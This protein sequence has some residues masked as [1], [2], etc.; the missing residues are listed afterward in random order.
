MSRLSAE[1]RIGRELEPGEIVDHNNGN[2]INDSWDEIAISNNC[3]NIINRHVESRSNTGHCGIFQ[4]DINFFQVYWTQGPHFKREKRYKSFP[5]LEDAIEFRDLMYAEHM[6]PQVING[7]ALNV[8][9]DTYVKGQQTQIVILQSLITYCQQLQHQSQQQQQ[10]QLIW[11]QML[12]EIT[13]EAFQQQ[14]LHNHQLVN[15]YFLSVYDESIPILKQKR[16]ELQ[17]QLNQQLS[18]Q[19]LQGIDPTLLSENETPIH[20]LVQGFGEHS[21]V[22]DCAEFHMPLPIE[23]RW[24]VASDVDWD[25]DNDDSDNNNDDNND[26]DTDDAGVE[27][28]ESVLNADNNSNDDGSIISDVSTGINVE[29]ELQLK[30]YREPF[31]CNIAL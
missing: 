25:D 10:Q 23:H 18:Q 19:L 17:C 6:L 28:D 7:R 12:S 14:L 29:L 5:V 26:D 22:H 27:T 11:L 21:Q 24:I 2:T 4:S 9:W 3:G 1:T 16:Q 30:S 8:A 20:K 31:H 13:E 15:T